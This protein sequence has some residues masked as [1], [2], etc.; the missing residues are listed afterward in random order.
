VT[1]GF[2]AYRLVAPLRVPATYWLGL[3]SPLMVDVDGVQTPTLSVSCPACE[4]TS[5]QL[6]RAG[7]SL[8]SAI[9]GAMT[10]VLNASDA[11]VEA[12][13]D[14]PLP[15]GAHATKAAGELERTTR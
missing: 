8:S 1:D 15:R 11:E 9:D 2:G 7:G 3:R 4:A 13:G 12:A 10:Y 14:P 5:V 6:S